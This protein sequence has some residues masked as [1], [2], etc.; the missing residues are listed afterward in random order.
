MPGAAERIIDEL[1]KF[2]LNWDGEI[3]YQSDFLPFYHQAIEKLQA[4]K[5]IYPCYCSRKTLQAA[6]PANPG[7]YPGICRQRSEI[8]P[9]PHALRVVAEDASLTFH[10][11][12][13]NTVTQNLAK[14][15]GDFIV[16]RKDEIIAYQLA[17][18]VDDYDSQITDVVRGFDLLDSTPRQIYLQQL[19]GY[20]TPHYMHVPILLNAL[21]QKLSKQTQAEAVN[22]KQP[23][24]TLWLILE[25]L[26]QSP[27]NQLRTDSVQT[28][29]DWAIEHWRPEKLNGLQHLSL[30]I[31]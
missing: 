8:E 24:K 12:I 29:L 5:T 27:P 14:S 25:L 1:I 13:Q 28:I 21:G 10:D 19:L 15:C 22:S 3:T 23:G 20:P 2:G 11:R 30:D 18:V 4:I 7:Y 26:Q 9:L 16:C 31:H 6:S 17:V